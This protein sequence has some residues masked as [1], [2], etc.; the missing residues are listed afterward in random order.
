MA[1][2]EESPGHSPRAHYSLAPELKRK[3]VMYKAPGATIPRK[4]LPKYPLFTPEG[5]ARLEIARQT[6][7]SAENRSSLWS[8]AGFELVSF[9]FILCCLLFSF[10]DDWMII[11]SSRRMA[12]QF[13][14]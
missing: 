1:F 14:G 4:A 5:S 13:K 10:S 2:P 12:G 9:S 6:G 11:V 8:P 3:I 7:L